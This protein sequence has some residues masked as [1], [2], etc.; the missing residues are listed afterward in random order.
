MRSN[1]TVLPSGLMSTDIQ[2][3]SLVEKD[4][5]LAGFSGK[6]LY[7]VYFTVSFLVVSA[8]GVSIG[9]PT[10]TKLLW[11]E[12]Q[13]VPVISSA[14]RMT[15]VRLLRRTRAEIIR[16]VFLLMQEFTIV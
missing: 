3:P 16:N 4:I 6:L 9:W 7:S 8:G 5:F 15:K 2:V 13:T 1:N 14:P 11:T 12:A 10:G